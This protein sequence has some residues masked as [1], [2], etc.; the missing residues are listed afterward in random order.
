VLE[1]NIL[2]KI[3]LAFDIQRENRISNT[4]IVNEACF[5][6]VPRRLRIILESNEQHFISEATKPLAF[7]DILGRNIYR[8]LKLALVSGKHQHPHV[9]HPMVDIIPKLL[10]V[11]HKCLVVLF[12]LQEK[13]RSSNT[14][15]WNLADIF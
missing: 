12:K 14:K 2:W 5:M 7:Y 3:P 11:L 6:C 9:I 10:H 1:N 13:P 8:A 4:E 15:R